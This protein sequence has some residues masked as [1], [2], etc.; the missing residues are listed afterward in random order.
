MEECIF[1]KIAAHEIE[2]KIVFEDEYLV[3]FHD[4]RPKTPIHILIIPRKH[5]PTINDLTEDDQELV[6]K[7]FLRAKH[8]AKEFELSD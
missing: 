2:A 3:A 6:G 7:M 5:I 8:L 1:C 4:I